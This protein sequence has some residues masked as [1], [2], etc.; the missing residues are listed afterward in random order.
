[1]LND[2]EIVFSVWTAERNRFPSSTAVALAAMFSS[3]GGEY[4]YLYG[5]CRKQ[6]LDDEGHLNPDLKT[7]LT[8]KEALRLEELLSYVK[9]TKKEVNG[10]TD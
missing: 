2:D 8:E 10:G 7:V 4:H 9:V 1:M 5:L 3:E 6:L